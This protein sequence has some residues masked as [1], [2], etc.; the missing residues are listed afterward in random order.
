MLAH[1]VV[2]GEAEGHG[3]GLERVGVRRGNIRLYDCNQDTPCFGGHQGLYPVLEIEAYS[4][5][6]LSK[7]PRL[8]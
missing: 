7:K 5:L 8:E 6:K 2:E 3:E 1:C 4:S